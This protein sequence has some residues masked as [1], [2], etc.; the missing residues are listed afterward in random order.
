MAKR[1]PK[2]L[3]SNRNW[4]KWM[5]I[6]RNRACVYGVVDVYVSSAGG[7]CHVRAVGIERAMKRVPESASLLGRYAVP[8]DARQFLA[9]VE[10]HF[11]TV[12]P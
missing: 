4:V 9:D 10:A 12:Q 11:C 6:A 8:F 2:P 5:N 3:H 1:G 7:D